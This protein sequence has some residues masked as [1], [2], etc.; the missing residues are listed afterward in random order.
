METWKL[1]VTALVVFL[2]WTASVAIM[3]VDLDPVSLSLGMAT[4]IVVVYLSVR[5]GQRLGEKQVEKRSK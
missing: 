2:V 3:G 4:V 1:M 5:F